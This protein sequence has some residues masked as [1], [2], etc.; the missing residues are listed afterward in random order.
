MA[1]ISLIQ[2]EE[3][4]QG[5]TAPSPIFMKLLTLV[6][7]YERGLNLEFFFNLTSRSRAMEVQTCDLEENFSFSN[8]FKC[9]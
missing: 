5:L 1:Q 7:L 2:I 8:S 9:L 3:F 6:H 4:D